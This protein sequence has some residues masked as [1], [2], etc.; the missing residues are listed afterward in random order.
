MYLLALFV[1]ANLW[2]LNEQRSHLNHKFCRFFAHRFGRPTITPSCRTE[3]LLST[4]FLH[5]TFNR[6]R[7]FVLLLLLFKWLHPSQKRRLKRLSAVTWPFIL[8]LSDQWCE[9]VV[10][11]WLVFLYRVI[12]FCLF[13]VLRMSFQTCNDSLWYDL[14]IWWLMTISGLINHQYWLWY[15]GLV[16][17]CLC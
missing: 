16:N 9:L 4:R 13:D 11:V 1:L 12:L 5:T 15:S 2:V 10:K 7:L 8:L 6:K 17:G 14:T 3:S